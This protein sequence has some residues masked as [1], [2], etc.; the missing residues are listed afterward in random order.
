MGKSIILDALVKREDFWLKSNDE[1]VVES[2][3]KASSIT[4]E[5][6]KSNSNLVLSMRKPDFQRETNQWDV[7]QTINFIKSFID[8][9][10]VPSVIFW[11]SPSGMTFIIDGAHRISALRAWIEN[12]Y[13]DGLI[14][15]NFFDGDIPQEQ[16]NAANSIRKKIKSEIGSY[17]DLNKKLIERNSDPKIKIDP[18][19]VTRLRN[20]ATRELDLQWVSGNAEN[21]ER[22]FFKINTQGTPLDKNEE[23]ILRNRKKSLAIAAR[24]IIRS[25]TGH[26]Y[27]SDFSEEKQETI[28][29]LSIE[30]NNL[31]FKPEINEPVR[32]LQLPIGGQASNTSSLSILIRMLGLSDDVKIGTDKKI[33]TKDDHDG[34]LTIKT[35]ERCKKIMN[36]ISGNESCSLGFHPAVY[37]YSERGKN[38]PDIF[39]G[40]YRLIIDKEKNNDREF[41]KNFTKSR[42][43]IESFLLHN[44]NI[45]NQMM[46]GIRSGDRPEKIQNMFE[47]LV[48]E[49]NYRI[50]DIFS[51][52]NLKGSVVSIKQKADGKKF[53][54]ETK[55]SAFIKTAIQT[56]LKCPI[57]NG[58][59]E[60]SM[61]VSYDH[62][63]PI[64]DGG[65]G[66]E[67]NCSLTHG[68][69]N[70][71]MKS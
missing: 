39:L 44:K 11:Q 21:A 40:I 62:F 22:S 67:E 68:Y 52:L 20:L 17:E 34:S 27:W 58:Y 8:G 28:Q 18:T 10:L 50:E 24:S 51:Y 32:T 71:S 1:Q 2:S 6:L 3:K 14:S 35:L 12:D 13:G 30:I 69:C 56:A 43:K 15:L 16:R 64:R 41:Y 61:S 38:I 29:K 37:F 31:L 66:D 47:Y 46:V 55:S 5:N 26:K 7:N 57:C 23:I 48:K 19:L 33:E 9:E 45:I 53:S 70:S 54:N 63:I 59:L 60:P 65:T 25:A 49:N 4:I 36:V 42:E